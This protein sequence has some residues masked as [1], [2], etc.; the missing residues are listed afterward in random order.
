VDGPFRR[1]VRRHPRRGRL[2]GWG[3]LVP[4]PWCADGMFHSA[5]LDPGGQLDYH[6]GSGYPQDGASQA[7]ALLLDARPGETIVDACAAPGSKSTQ[8]GHALGDD[9]LLICCD[10]SPERRRVL[11]EVCARQGLANAVITPMAPEILAERHPGCADAVLVDAPCSG[12]MPRS[13]RQVARMAQ[14]QSALLDRLV[15][16]VRPG[17]RLV[18]S[19]CTPY[20]EENEGVVAAFLD[21]HAGWR[22]DACVLP[23]CDTDLLALGALR[24]WPQRQGTE[25]FF[26]CRLRAP[27]SGSAESVTG[28][29]PEP[30]R[31]IARWLPSTPLHCWRRGNAL[32][33]ATPAAAACA[34]PAEA[35]G[36]L[37][38]HARV[39]GD[40]GLL[41]PWA[42]QALIERGAAARSV[43]HAFAAELWAGDRASDFAAGEL[44]KT[45]AEAPLGVIA[46]GGR[47]ALPSRLRRSGL[48]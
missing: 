10:R 31:S 1:A 34:L 41:E 46:S 16:L 24:M 7:P 37:L 15:P 36:I 30:D 23:G 27:G 19:T 45:D 33:L 20:L 44:V 21:R 25:P 6:T 35:R 4:V 48:R 40:D 9:G 42:A 29:L 43:P 3:E 11:V 17:G 2:T 14:R 5:E 47:L 39:N 26:A 22:I 12:H 28:T 13:Q 32:L 18:Y 38:G 8:I